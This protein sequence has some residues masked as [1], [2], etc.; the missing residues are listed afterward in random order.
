M[1]LP[2]VKNN[3]F[4]LS[5]KYAEASPITY[6]TND[7]APFLIYYSENDP[8]VPARQAATMCKKLKDAGVPYKEFKNPNQGHNPIPDMN[9]VDNWFK[10]YLK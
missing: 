4:I 6:V 5:G 9:E 2:E 1:N 3:E 7:D 8:I 10:R